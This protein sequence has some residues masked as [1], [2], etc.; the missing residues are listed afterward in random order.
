MLEVLTVSIGA[1]STGRPLMAQVVFADEAKRRIAELEAALDAARKV[2]D[3]LEAD[4]IRT[5]ERNQALSAAL[6]KAAVKFRDYQDYH[7]A[8][9][10]PE[11]NAKAL[12]N[13]QLALMCETALGLHPAKTEGT[14]S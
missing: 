9:D 1:D 4:Q 12:A 13:G 8:K 3:E 11:G 10:T 6:R 14:K 5:V 7:L 2:R